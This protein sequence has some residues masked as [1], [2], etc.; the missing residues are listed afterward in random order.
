MTTQS[1][2][3]IAAEYHSSLEAINYREAHPFPE[4]FPTDQANR[5]MILFK[6]QS[7]KDFIAGV[8]FLQTK[9]EQGWISVKERLPK[10]SNYISSQ[11]YLVLIMG[12]FPS[13]SRY[14][15]GFGKEENKNDEFRNVNGDGT[16]DR[17]HSVTHWMEIP[18]PPQT[19]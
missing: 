11:Q 3:Q 10:P 9:M 14:M 5:L 1:E 16:I 12:R 17:F 7:K 15:K 8:D 18:S 2:I 4:L 19:I 6:T 13:I